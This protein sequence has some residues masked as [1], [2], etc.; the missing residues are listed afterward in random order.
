MKT[1]FRCRACQKE[2]FHSRRRSRRAAHLE[3]ICSPQSA[4]LALAPGKIGFLT[5]IASNDPYAFARTYA[6]NIAPVNDNAPFFFF[7]LNLDQ[8]LHHQ[9]MEEGMDWKVN[10][11]VAV[12][13][14][15][16]IISFAA[17]DSLPDLPL[18][19]G[20]WHQLASMREACCIS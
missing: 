5:L 19:M 20:R 3:Q 4:L 14:M 15:V 6:Y 18:A 11:G 9:G 16:L 10:L 12:L 13:G 8:I 1:E 17:C 2:F 7:T